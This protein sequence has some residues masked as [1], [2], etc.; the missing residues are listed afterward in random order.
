MSET[1]IDLLTKEKEKGLFTCNQSLD[2]YV[3]GLR[4]RYARLFGEILPSKDYEL[5]VEKLKEKNIL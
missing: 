4:I 1:A 2:E 5:I 3:E